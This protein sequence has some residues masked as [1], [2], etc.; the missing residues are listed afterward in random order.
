MRATLKCNDVLFR[1]GPAI[2]TAI[3]IKKTSSKAKS[4]IHRNA[5]PVSIRNMLREQEERQR[6]R[7]AEQK[8]K[9]RAFGFKRDSC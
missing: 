8:E 7:N 5:K 1:K 9:K 2:L 6:K 4:Y 3:K